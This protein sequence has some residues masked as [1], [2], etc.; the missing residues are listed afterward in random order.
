MKELYLEFN[1][2]NQLMDITLLD[3]DHIYFYQH[4]LTEKNQF[5]IVSKDFV[6]EKTI[7]TLKKNSFEIS[8]ELFNH[9]ILNFNLYHFSLKRIDMIK[10]FPDI[11]E[12]LI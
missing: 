11:E 6:K 9:I 5:S 8:E 2:Q 3:D 10:L 12:H 7:K 4:D 1:E